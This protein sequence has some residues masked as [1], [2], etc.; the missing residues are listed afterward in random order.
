MRILARKPKR[1]G[2]G[3]ALSVWRH[4]SLHR[5]GRRS[6]ERL[7]VTIG[8]CQPDAV[9]YEGVGRWAKQDSYAAGDLG[10]IG[11]R[12]RAVAPVCWL[13]PWLTP[14]C[15]LLKFLFYLGFGSLL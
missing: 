2:T 8:D 11:T 10:I 13:W 3:V 12:V 14:F 4:G 6:T 5:V 15:S 7:S 9:R 1:L